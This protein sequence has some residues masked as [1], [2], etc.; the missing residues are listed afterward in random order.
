MHYKG[1]VDDDSEEERG[2]NIMK[3]S[4]EAQSLLQ[5]DKRHDEYEKELKYEKGQPSIHNEV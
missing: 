1:C 5:N 3:K 4:K 2:A